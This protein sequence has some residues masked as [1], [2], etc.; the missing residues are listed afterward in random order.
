[1]IKKNLDKD[2]DVPDFNADIPLPLQKVGTLGH[3]F[4]IRLKLPDAPLFV[5]TCKAD[6]FIGLPASRRGVHISRIGETILSNYTKDFESPQQ[7]AFE[8]AK[9]VYKSQPS[10]GSVVNLS[11]FWTELDKTPATNLDSIQSYEII[12]S[13]CFDENK[14]H[15]SIGVKV[16]GITACPCVQLNAREYYRGLNLDEKLINKQLSKIPLFSHSQRVLTTS[17]LKVYEIQKAFSIDFRQII[18]IVRN[19]ISPTYDLLKR[20]DE[21]K[22]VENAHLY[23]LFCEDITRVLALNITKGFKEIIPEN[24]ELSIDVLSMESIHSYNLSSEL[25]MQVSEIKRDFKLD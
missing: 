13:A 21:V 11:F 18:K 12:A 23:P 15:T 24:S 10:M 17:Q 8:L 5:S 6:I 20:I 25:R 9:S 14:S 22:V 19:S 4:P 7:L 2:F 1:M 16:P 3:I